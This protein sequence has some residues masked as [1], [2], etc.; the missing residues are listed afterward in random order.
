MDIGNVNGKNIIVETLF[1]DYVEV[2]SKAIAARP[3]GELATGVAIKTYYSFDQ[4]DTIS[5]NLSILFS[6]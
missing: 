6:K 5:Y 4:L 3:C 1:M 2:S